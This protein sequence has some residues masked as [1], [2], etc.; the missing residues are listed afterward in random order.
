MKKS[1]LGLIIIFSALTLVGCINSNDNRDKSSKTQ[2][3]KVLEIAEKRAIEVY[4]KD[5]IEDEK[6]LKATLKEAVWHVEGT[7]QCEDPSTEEIKTD[8]C[9]GGVVEIEI[10]DKDLKIL[11]ITHG[12]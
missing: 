10:S 6:P 4:G 11:K 3:E 5:Q 12:E 7:L 1:L 8:G 2:E 9:V